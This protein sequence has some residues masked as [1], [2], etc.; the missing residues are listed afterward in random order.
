MF[1]GHAV[2]LPAAYPQVRWIVGGFEP[3]QVSVSLSAECDSVWVSWVTVRAVISWTPEHDPFTSTRKTR[4]SS[5]R[6]PPNPKSSTKTLPPIK[7]LSK[8]SIETQEKFKPKSSTKTQ[9]KS[10]PKPSTMRNKKEQERSVMLGGEENK[11]EMRLG[12]KREEKRASF[13]KQ[14][15]WDPPPLDLIRLN[16]WFPT[17]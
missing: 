17:N 12:F 16:S 14:A 8:S 4:A 6:D 2:D 11:E 10:K 3:E 5:S 13:E 9:A 7:T 1:R 15:I